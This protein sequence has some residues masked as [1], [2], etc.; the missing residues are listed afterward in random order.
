[1]VGQEDLEDQADQV[2]LAVQ[3]VQVDDLAALDR[4]GVQTFFRDA[5]HKVDIGPAEETHSNDSSVPQ[6]Y[7]TIVRFADLPMPKQRY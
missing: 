2:G 3:V 6:V 1:M 5:F 7:K 4:D